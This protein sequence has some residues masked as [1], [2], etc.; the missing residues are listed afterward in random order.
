MSNKSRLQQNNTDLQSIKT[1]AEGLPVLPTVTIDG[2]AVSGNLAL[3][4]DVRDVVLDIYPQCSFYNGFTVALN[5]E[6]HVFGHDVTHTSTLI[7]I[8][9]HCKWNGT[10]WTSASTLPSNMQYGSAVVLNNEIHLIYNLNHY[11]WNGSSWTSVST[12]PYSFSS[13][14]LVTFNNE[15]HAIGSSGEYTKRAHY[16]WNGTAWTS[17]SSLPIVFYGGGGVVVYNNEIHILGGS[18]GYYTDHY[19]WNGLS[20]TSV[21]TLPFNCNNGASVCIKNGEIH[22]VTFKSH[23]KYNGTTWDTLNDLPYKFNNNGLVVM[24][25]T[26]YL[27]GYY[28]YSDSIIY[29]KLCILQKKFYQLA[30]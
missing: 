15:I 9:Q 18:P 8:T 28:D 21:E 11:K 2:T 12:L 7:D 23:Y 3:V 20:W 6:I 22:V 17:V 5:G 26:I 4:S 27:L 25:G 29:N 10:T 16:K 24:D 30:S 13:G 1:I 14:H 19:K